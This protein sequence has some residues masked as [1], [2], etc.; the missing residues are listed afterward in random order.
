MPQ[1]VKR[2]IM[3]EDP[4]AEIFM[5][6]QHDPFG[7]NLKHF[8]EN[9]DKQQIRALSLGIGMR[10]SAAHGG[11]FGS[12]SQPALARFARFVIAHVLDLFI[13]L[14][15]TVVTFVIAAAFLAPKT[16]GNLAKAVIAWQPTQLILDMKVG[17][18]FVFAYS[19]FF[20]YW[21]TAKLL[22]GITIGQVCLSIYKSS[23]T[24]EKSE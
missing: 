2:D 8:V 16:H 23:L 9:L 5:Q 21:L 14:S 17:A 3:S 12:R 4:S 22:A 20:V 1:A 6:Q 7:A 19:L 24:T 18:F 11:R 15:T 10:A 13:A